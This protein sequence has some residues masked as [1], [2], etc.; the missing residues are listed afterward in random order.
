[1]VAQPLARRGAQSRLPHVDDTLISPRH[2]V[3]QVYTKSR[4]W[5]PSLSIKASQPLYVTV[6]NCWR[7]VQFCAAR[8][9]RVRG[10]ACRGRKAMKARKVACLAPLL[11][12]LLPQHCYSVPSN[13]KHELAGSGRTLHQHDATQQQQE[14]PTRRPDESAR[15]LR[16]EVGAAAANAAVDTAASRRDSSEEAPNIDFEVPD[17]RDYAYLAQNVLHSA[18]IDRSMLTT[19]EQ[20]GLTYLMVPYALFSEKTRPVGKYPSLKYIYGL[21]AAGNFYKCNAGLHCF[22]R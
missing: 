11:L 18:G 17:A 12:L 1:M 9:R 19:Q 10:A 5:Y 4:S 15:E 22:H 8:L 20:L 2:D 16:T 7:R 21:K 13:S 6:L 14:Q 3:T